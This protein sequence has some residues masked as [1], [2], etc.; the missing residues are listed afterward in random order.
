MSFNELRQKL[1]RCMNH[2]VFTH[3]V[4]ATGSSLLSVCRDYINKCPNDVEIMAPP[5]TCH[6]ISQPQP[7]T[8]EPRKTGA[9]RQ[10]LP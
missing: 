4:V 5:C 9:V 3:N 2:E 7:E 8:G 1:N 6:H 10:P